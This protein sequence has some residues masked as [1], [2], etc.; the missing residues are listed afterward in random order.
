[1]NDEAQAAAPT[2]KTRF[3]DK[4][5]EIAAAKAQEKASKLKQ[6]TQM[7]APALD[8]EEKATQDTQASALGLNGDTAT[9]K[10]KKKDKNAPKER[11]QQAAPAPP[12]PKPDE[13][14]VPPRS[15]R[16]NGEPAVAP[17]PSSTPA[18]A[19]PQ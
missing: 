9:K 10:K 16:E 11:M 15:V 2:K 13:T 3:A 19:N 17:A 1:L 7:V 6:R 18:P 14:P 12:A 4:Q 8:T 5:P